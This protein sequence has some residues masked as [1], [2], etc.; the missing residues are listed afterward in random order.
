MA[1]MSSRER[2]LAA[3]AC[4]EPDRV[5][6]FELGIDPLLAAKLMGWEGPNSGV[7]DM[8]ARKHTVAEMKALAAYLRLDNIAISVRAP[9]YCERI[10]GQDG[11]LFYGD[12][13]IKTEADLDKVRLPDPYDDRLYES[14]AELV[15]NKGD[16]AA[17]LTTRIGI[18]PA[19]LSMGMEAFS[20]AL[21]ENRRFLETMLD[22]YFGWTEVVAERV[23]QMGFDVFVSTD[24]HAFKS[25][26]FLSPAVWRELIIPR[27]QRVARKITI[28]W[29]MHSD[30][31]IMGIVDDLIGLGIRG[32]H[33]NEKGAMDIRYMKRTYGKRICL[34]G[35]VDLNLLGIGTAE[36]VDTEV[37]DLIR[38]IGPGGGYMV[39]SGNSLASYL[40]PT[41]VLAM[42][43]AVQKYGVYPLSI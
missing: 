15:R 36:E 14:A 31:N 21:Y 1:T 11:R 2:V 41:N 4:Q 18:F 35:N 27:Y 23:C 12:G 3:L 13:L 24:D 8:D 19:L 5:P 20:V 17:C 26:L 9:V 39:A 37:R 42:S 7:I 6:F 40:N 10:P 28:P 25:G 38:D 32:L 33:P 30:G 34:L 22:I 43:N 29:V 16:F